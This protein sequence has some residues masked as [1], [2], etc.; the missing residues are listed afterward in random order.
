QTVHELPWRHAA[1]ENSGLSH[2]F[3]A[4][5]GPWRADAVICPTEFVRTDLLAESPHGHSRVHACH[6]GIDPGFARAAVDRRALIEKYRLPD[7]P[8]AVL[9]GA[10]RPKKNLAAALRALAIAEDSDLH[11]VV[12][13]K[14]TPDLLRDV[15]LAASLGLRA[16]LHTLGEIVCEDLPCLIAMARVTLVLS[17]SEGFG[18][19]TLES[20]A[21]ATP[22]IVAADSAQ[23]EVAGDA[24]IVTRP[25]DPASLWSAINI[26]LRQTEA[27]RS[28]LPLRAAQFSWREC[29]QRVE[30]IWM[31]WAR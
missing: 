15:D 10:T 2:R 17:T 11:L 18:F 20:L 22:V 28:A 3:W 25:G 31:S 23:A 16:R 5:F 26:A 6:W 7:A 14:V 21:C 1:R 9:L 24:G 13:G 12:T 8:F 30:E 27:E 29:A 19:P 4:R